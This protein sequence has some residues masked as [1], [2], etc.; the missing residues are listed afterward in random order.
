M[1][2]EYYVRLRKILQL[3]LSFYNKRIFYNVFV[4]LVLIPTF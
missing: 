3:D 1:T 2:L 4:V